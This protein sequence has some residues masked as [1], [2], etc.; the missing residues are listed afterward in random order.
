MPIGSL[1][2][3]KQI[4]HYFDVAGDQ[5]HCTLEDD[6]SRNNRAYWYPANN[7]GF[8]IDHNK[9]FNTPEACEK[10]MKAEIKKTC[11][12]YLKDL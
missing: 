2:P 5:F 11:K 3:K 6:Y 9:A 7:S 12:L 10:Y 8:G 4:A 1:Y